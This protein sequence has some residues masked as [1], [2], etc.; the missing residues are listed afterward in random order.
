MAEKVSANVGGKEIHIETGKYGKQAHGAVTI[1]LG[2]TIVFVAAVGAAKPRPGQEWFPL[3]VDYRE[4]AAAAGRFPGG[5]FKREGRPTEKEIL[6]CRLTDRPIRPLFPKGW[7]NETQIQSIVMSADGENDPDILSILGASAALAV[8]DIPWGGP[9]GAVRVGRVEGEFVINP[10]HTEMEGSD[11]DLIYVGNEKDVVMFEGAANE[12]SEADFNAALKAAHEACQPII[13]AQKALVEKAGKTKREF[14]PVLP[15]EELVNE[16]VSFVGNRLKEA[17][18][19]ES[20]VEREAACSA[21]SDELAGH[22]VEKFT[23]EVATDAVINDAFYQIQKTAARSLMIDDGRRLDGRDFGD[24]RPLNSEVGLLPRCHGSALFSRG[25]TL[26][27]ANAT[28][29]TKDDG[30]TFDTFTGGV[31]EK[32]FILHYNFPNFSVG[33]TGRIMGPG[34]REIGHGALA[35]RSLAPMIPLHEFP[36][37]VRVVSEIME[38]NGSTSMASICGG[39]LA[40]MDAGVPMIRP[41]AGISVGICTESDDAGNIKDN[42]RLLT[43][44]IGWED[45]FADMDCKIAGTSNGITGFQLDLKLK[46][47]PHDIMAQALDQ[48]RDARLKILESMAD[49]LAEPRKDLSPYAPRILTLTIDPDKIGA[50]I[51]PGGKN[52][53][54]IVEESGCEINIEDDGTVQIY[55][56]SADGMEIARAAIEQMTAEIEVNKI[57]KGKVVTI[58]EFGCFVEVFPGKDGLCHISE[59]ANFRVKRTEDIVKLGDEIWVKCLGIDDKGRVKLSRRAA[60]EER[61]KQMQD[62]AESEEN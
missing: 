28:L 5:F 56:V 13:E 1:Q 20:K 14:E 19:V 9:L 7:M 6:T 59:L 21:L 26:T 31:G 61:D 40:L 10:T 11:L 51:G 33:E 23:D 16:A 60:M 48:A 50:L 12:I 4:R 22:L 3:T 38:S 17:L 39:S 41:V 42:Y 55:S 25:E 34:R 46:G 32:Q 15:P 24:L 29:S 62:E 18:L 2:E 57:Y 52:I 45:A 58:K 36:Y 49:T 53:K 37:A 44:I 47:L 8:S 54:R 27:I 30:Q 35:E 43:D